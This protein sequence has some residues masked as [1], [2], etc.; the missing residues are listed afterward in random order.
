MLRAPTVKIASVKLSENAIEHC[1]RCMQGGLLRRIDPDQKRQGLHVSRAPKAGI[2]GCLAPAFPITG[3]AKTPSSHYQC[4]GN[5][6]IP[7][8]RFIRAAVVKIM[9]VS[10]MRDAAGRVIGAH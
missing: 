9:R 2:F 5:S 7:A 4:P 8:R 3:Q 1:I 10:F 6:V